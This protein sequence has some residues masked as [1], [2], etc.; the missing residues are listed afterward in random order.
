VS[1]RRA[2]VGIVVVA[3]VA[4]IAIVLATPGF[5]A[6]S[7]AGDFDRIAVSLVRHGG[8][9]ESLLT[10]SGGPT[11]FRPPLFPLALAG[12]YELSGTGSYATRLEA[13]RML[14]AVLGAVTVLLIALIATRMWNRR[15]GL[16]AGGIAA[17]YP[18][19]WVAGMSL[20]SESLFIPLVLAAI[21]AALRAREPPHRLQWAIA[22][23]ALAGFAALTRGNGIVLL[24]PLALL[25]WGTPMRSLSSLRAPAA[26]VA[27]TVITLLPWTIRNA[28][29]FHQFV[30]L[31]TETGYALAGTYNPVSQSDSQ[32]PALW[33]FPASQLTTYFRA[34]PRAN[35]AQVSDHLTSQALDYIGN[36]PGSILRTTFWSVARAFNLTG[37]GVEDYLAPFQGYTKG[38]VDASVY[39]FWLV[40]ALAAAATLAGAASSMPKALW[41]WPIVIVL[42]CSIFEGD[43][44][45]R[46]PCDPFFVML[47]AAG[48]SLAWERWR[49]PLRSRLPLA[50]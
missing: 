48:V 31:T 25:V 3:L 28:E 27:A 12:V 2:L 22:S 45:Y 23:G 7:D 46:S 43:S 26:L 34:D 42:S 17:V 15:V 36:H 32:Y 6:V 30:P 18:P 47:A 11:A 39:V 24:I 4:R 33:R 8:F 35:E 21:L 50:D 10:A 37:V 16:L 5:K 41:A 19:L 29:Q 44:R 14:E 40:L 49:S 20:L 13:G 1:W 38:L 9:P